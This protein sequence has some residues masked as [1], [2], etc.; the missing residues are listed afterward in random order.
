MS[1][2][3]SCI[4]EHIYIADTCDLLPIEEIY[5]RYFCL[6]PFVREYNNSSCKECDVALK[7]EAEV[8]L[9]AVFKAFVACSAFDVV[10]GM[11]WLSL[12]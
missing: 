9:S 6:T 10:G 8:A 5:S 3:N 1:P 12:Y 7:A 11:L 2:V 4:F